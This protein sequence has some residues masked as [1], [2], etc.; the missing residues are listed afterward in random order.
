MGAIEA[1]NFH[2][3]FLSHNNILLAS[4]SYSLARK[5]ERVRV[6]VSKRRV[7]LILTFSLREKERLV[8]CTVFVL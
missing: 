1:A 6:R 8:C 5:R 4:C 7:A 3:R 2:H